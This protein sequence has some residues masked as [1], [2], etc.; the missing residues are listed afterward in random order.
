MCGIRIVTRLSL[1]SALLLAF[2]ATH[3]QSTVDRLALDRALAFG[4]GE[5]AKLV[6]TAMTPLI[7]QGCDETGTGADLYQPDWSFMLTPA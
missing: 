6:S 3:A 1:C 2:T 5:G 7:N 4:G